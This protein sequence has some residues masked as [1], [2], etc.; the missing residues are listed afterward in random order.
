V[1]GADPQSALVARPEGVQIR[2]RRRG[3]NAAAVDA[4]AMVRTSL[5]AATL[6]ALAA[7]WTPA[8]AQFAVS[9]ANPDPPPPVQLL[10]SIMLMAVA[11]AVIVWQGTALGR[12]ALA[13]RRRARRRL[14]DA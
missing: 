4:K 1:D 10:I 13:R 9:S 8:L 11:A 14:Q 5:L 2:G 3:R 12:E 6:I 7:S